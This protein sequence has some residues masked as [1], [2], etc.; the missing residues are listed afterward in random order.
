MCKRKAQIK[1]GLVDR[2]VVSSGEDDA[3]IAAFTEAG[4]ALWLKSGGSY[5]DDARSR[6]TGATRVR[7]ARPGPGCAARFGDLGSGA[8]GSCGV[9]FY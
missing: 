7:R 2:E 5:T 4:R 3:Y 6:A 8:S 1:T 9:Q